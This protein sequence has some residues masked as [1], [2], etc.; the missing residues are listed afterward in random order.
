MGSLQGNIF[1]LKAIPFL[2]GQRAFV[3]R[4]NRD[5]TKDVL[6]HVEKGDGN[7]STESMVTVKAD[8]TSAV[9]IKFREVKLVYEDGS[10]AVPTTTVKV[11]D[12][13]GDGAES[14]R[15]NVRWSE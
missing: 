14:K 1:A 9:C 7:W 15:K 8:A 10:R 11:A 2:A 6:D 4:L 12:L 5:Q 13:A 3:H